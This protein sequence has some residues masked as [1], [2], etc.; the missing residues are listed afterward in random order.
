MRRLNMKI[1]KQ[2]L[3]FFILVFIYGCATSQS[4]ISEGKVYQ[5]MSKTSLRNILLDVYP[6][7]D[8]FVPNS[9]SEYNS[10]KKKEIISGSSKNLFYVFKDVYKP[11]VCGILL[12]KYGDGSLV[13]WHYSLTSAR[14]S[15]VESE[16]IIKQ[17]QPKITNLSTSD[18]RDHI[19]ALNQLIEDLESG[20][21]TEAEFN[22]KKA[23][24]LK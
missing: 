10:S 21:I 14:A 23:Q 3:L 15:L 13:S 20:K 17:E 18:N 5:G 6:N 7:E 4:L 9:F 2:Y 16:N 24:I 1:K 11:T 12:C 22:Q 8:P 19:E